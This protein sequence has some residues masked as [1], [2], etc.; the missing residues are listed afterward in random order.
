MAKWLP[1]A[2]THTSTAQPNTFTQAHHFPDFLP[3]F[4]PVQYSAR[5]YK[6]LDSVHASFSTL[7]SPVRVIAVKSISESR[8]MTVSSPPV[9]PI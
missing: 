9:G 1:T 6:C 5:S 3:P 7:S 2:P 8:L 4:P